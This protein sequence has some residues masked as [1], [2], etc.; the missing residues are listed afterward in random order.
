MVEAKRNAEIRPGVFSVSAV[1]G[2]ALASGS[3]M[4]TKRV[5]HSQRMGVMAVTSFLVV[6]LYESHVLGERCPKMESAGSGM[7]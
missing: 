7:G 3:T 1:Q 5:A 6:L 2:G 4:W